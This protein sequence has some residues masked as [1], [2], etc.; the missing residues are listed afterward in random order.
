MRQSRLKRQGITAS[1]MAPLVSVCSLIMFCVLDLLLSVPY[2]LLC[3]YKVGSKSF[4]LLYS[5]C[6]EYATIPHL[7]NAAHK[8]ILVLIKIVMIANYY[9]YTRTNEQQACRQD[10]LHCM[11]WVLGSWKKVPILY[12]LAPTLVAF[13]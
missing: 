8:Q 11:R 12:S 4:C 3:S 2:A 1:I 6:L 5:L 10:D 7:N 13:L 9:F